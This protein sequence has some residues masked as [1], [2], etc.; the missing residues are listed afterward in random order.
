[1]KRDFDLIRIIVA[2]I[3]TLQPGHFAAESSFTGYLGL[4]KKYDRAVILE[5]IG[6]L[7]EEDFI[8]GKTHKSYDG[9]IDSVHITGLTWKG[10][11]FIDAAKDES[12]WNK[13]KETILKPTVSIT[14]SLL[15]EWL[16]EEAKKKIGLS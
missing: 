9:N 7:L 16:K 11:D 1:M 6:L 4:D 13:A 2:H 3:E 10:H 14:F 15:L 12:I 8:K 5:H